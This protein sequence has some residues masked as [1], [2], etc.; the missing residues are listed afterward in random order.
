MA[1]KQFTFSR[2]LFFET[3]YIDVWNHTQRIKDLTRDFNLETI[4][5]KKINHDISTF[6]EDSVLIMKIGQTSRE[7]PNAKSKTFSEDKATRLSQE[8][9]TDTRNLPHEVSDDF[10]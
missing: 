1:Y 5:R 8:K 4:E 7:P 9:L 6:A 2:F 10:R 3:V